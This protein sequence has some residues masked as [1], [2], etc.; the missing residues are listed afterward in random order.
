VP[1]SV[2][3]VTKRADGKLHPPGGSLPWPQRREVIGL[4]HASRCRD[5]LS[6]RATQR[7]LAEAGYRRSIGIIYHDVTHY[8]CRYCQPEAFEPAEAA[9]PATG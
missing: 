4:A 7:A 1:I 3:L 8:G 5:G 2:V 9:E 6:Y